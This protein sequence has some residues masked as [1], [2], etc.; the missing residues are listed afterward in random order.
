MLRQPIETVY[1]E[2]FLRNEAEDGEEVYMVG[3]Y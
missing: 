2:L 3:V 1:S